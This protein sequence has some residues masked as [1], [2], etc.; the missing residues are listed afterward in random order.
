MSLSSKEHDRARD[1]MK[2]KELSRQGEKQIMAGFEIKFSKTSTAQGAIS[3][4]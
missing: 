3:K 1:N 2:T 4:S